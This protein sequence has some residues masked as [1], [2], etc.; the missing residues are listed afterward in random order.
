LFLKKYE[1]KVDLHNLI[2]EKHEKKSPEKLEYN[3][4]RFGKRS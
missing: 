2:Y 1:S 4:K 3:F